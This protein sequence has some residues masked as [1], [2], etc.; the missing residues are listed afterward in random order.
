MA[1]VPPTVP[2]PLRP[3]TRVPPERFQLPIERMREGYYADKYFVRTRDA[4]IATG[5]DPVVVMQVFQ[6]QAAWLGGVDEA[7]AILKTCLTD[8]YSWDQLDV[9]ALH[10]GDAV[11]PRETVMTIAGPYTAFAHL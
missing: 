1:H 10:D 3:V 7:I 8:G 11:Q 9:R 4:L 5:R 6:K 2:P